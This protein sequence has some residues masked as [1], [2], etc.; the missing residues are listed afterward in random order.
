MSDRLELELRALEVE[1]PRTPPFELD[2][3][4]RA[5]RDPL[6][7]RLAPV[8][9][10]VLAAL[11]AVGAAVEPVRAKIE[12]L[13]GIS[14]K[15]RVVRVPRVPNAVPIHLG[16]VV[17]LA[18]ARRRA[19]FEPLQVRGLRPTAVRLGG[20]NGPRAVSL[21]YGR[22][23]VLTETPDESVYPG[24]K[25]VANGVAVRFPRIAGSQGI[26]VAAGPRVIRLQGY[27]GVVRTRRAALPGA[28]VLLWNRHNVALRLETRRGYER[29][30]AL[31]R[32][33]R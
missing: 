13:L 30:V 10:A 3:R 1:W 26:W 23:V 21:F 31:A 28:G 11:V 33:V 9:A 4:T 32:Q 19:G 20:D 22:D 6:R 18:Q 25:E 2:L 15:E 27:D 16:R 29:A 17:T 12:A 8:L 7:R 14:G 24:V 5:A